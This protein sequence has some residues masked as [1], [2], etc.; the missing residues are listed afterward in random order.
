MSLDFM[1]EE[2]KPVCVFDA[3]ITHNLGDMAYE[4][5]I[6]H[7]LWRPEEVNAVYAKDIVSVLKE[8]IEAMKQ[9]PE[10][11]KKY[12]ADN[13]WGT[14]DDFLPWLER[15]KKACI[16]NPNAKIRVHR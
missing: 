2:E 8:G 16:E 12:D 7:A 9:D 4:A 1:L 14:Y 3:N 13:G 6:Y 11:F 15:V 10:R 5:G